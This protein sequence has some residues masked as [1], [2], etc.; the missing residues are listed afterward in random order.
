MGQNCIQP[1]EPEV[2]VVA[3]IR[4]IRLPAIEQSF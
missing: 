4:V 1:L 3:L 2:R